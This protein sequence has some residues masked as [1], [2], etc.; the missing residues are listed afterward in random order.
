MSLLFVSTVLAQF[1]QT[2]FIQNTGA[3]ESKWTAVELMSALLSLIGCLALA[4]VKLIVLNVRA[5]RARVV[6]QID[7]RERAERIASK[8]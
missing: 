8:D 4:G 6:A 3:T 7:D 1:S 5:I 2:V